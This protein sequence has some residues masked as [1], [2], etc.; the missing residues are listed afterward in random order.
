MRFRSVASRT[1]PGGGMRWGRSLA[2]RDDRALWGFEARYVRTDRWLG[3]DVKTRVGVRLRH[4]DVDAALH[5]TESRERLEARVD[6]AVSESALGAFAEVDVRNLFNSP[7]SQAQFANE[8]RLPDEPA[9]V[10]DLH[11]TS[12]YPLSAMASA[13]VFFW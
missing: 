8:S 1:G 12:G 10:Q 2:W 6:A 3:R 4:D 5:H 7:W 11:F 13:T 9:P